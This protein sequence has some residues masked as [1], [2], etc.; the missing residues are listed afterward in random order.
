M[1]KTPTIYTIRNSAG[2][3]VTTIPAGTRDN[4]TSLVLHG[5]GAPEYGLER[6]QN[7]VYLLENFSN[8]TP[9]DDPVEGQ[10]WWKT[11]VELFVWSSTGS[12][13]TG[14]WRTAVPPPGELG[15]TIIAGDG[16][17]EGGF[18]T[19]SPLQVLL[20]VGTF[21]TGI[22]VTANSISTNDSEIV[23]DNL[24]GFV[25]N[26]H[27]D[28][29]SVTLILSTG[30]TTI[31]ST[32]DASQTLGL[33]AGDGILSLGSPGSIAVDSTVVRTNNYGSPGAV[34]SIAGTKTF[35]VQLRGAGATIG[36]L[37]SYSFSAD[38]DT[39][40]YL[41]GANEMSFVTG[42]TQ[43]LCISSTGALVAQTPNYDTLVTEDDDIPNKKYVDDNIAVGGAPPTSNTF[44]G[45]SSLSGLKG[46]ETYL[47]QGWGVLPN[48]GTGG[49]TLSSHVCR[50]GSTT[51]A[52][53][54]VKGITGQRSINWMDGQCPTFA[55]LVIV[56][57]GDTTL[58][59]QINDTAHGGGNIC[60]Q[61]L[62]AVQLTNVGSPIPLGSPAG[63]I[64][65]VADLS[66][67]DED[68]FTADAYVYYDSTGEARFS[69]E[70][71]DFFS[72]V[73]LDWSPLSSSE[74]GATGWYVRL[75]Y[76]SG[77]SHVSIGGSSALNTWIQIST[78]P[79]WG[80]RNSDGGPSTN[81][82]TYSIELSHDGGSTIYDGPNNFSIT[83]FVQ[84]P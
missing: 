21:N 48:K 45:T 19:L 6:D 31:G 13:S 3:V 72:T 59:W 84:S 53:G 49:A 25:A 11:G 20:R 34:Q 35:S 42:G 2:D 41:S 4:T 76:V 80:F 83:L 73:T 57:G 44:V 46:N 12:P 60:S 17:N 23:H 75:Q 26:E 27:I 74:P 9:P 22:T 50:T 5:S 71:L 51:C 14:A 10:F 65:Q 38:T 56:M 32:I 64:A 55:S 33:G 58:N 16:L 7:L 1:A 81:I 67:L 62:T 24:S 82:G 52:S 79:V 66:S 43:R 36:S 78:N 30:F 15:F 40:I 39:G 28:H 29:S 8:S 77:V 37:P 18:P 69:E 61:Y 68:G 63:Y 70:T 47:V 54:A